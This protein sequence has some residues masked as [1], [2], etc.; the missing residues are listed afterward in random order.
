MNGAV[1]VAAA[2]RHSVMQQKVPTSARLPATEP[3]AV[4]LE[5]W[6][7]Q[8]GRGYAIAFLSLFAT[9][10]ISGIAAAVFQSAR[11]VAIAI[12]AFGGA[13]VFGIAYHAFQR[14]GFPSGN[15]KKPRVLLPGRNPIGY[16]LFVTVAL[17]L[18]FAIVGFGVW[19]WVNADA[20]DSIR[21][22]ESTDSTQV[23]ECHPLSAAA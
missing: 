3:V 14:I 12:S 18:S 22:R 16:W 13:G 17:A 23:T 21:D 6:E 20:V 4:R 7:Q 2:D 1:A 5:G 19:L 11:W 10:M 15:L 8:F 9:V